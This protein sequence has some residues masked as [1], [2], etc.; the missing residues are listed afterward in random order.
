[1]YTYFIPFLA[2]SDSEPQFGEARHLRE[3]KMQLKGKRIWEKGTLL[4]KL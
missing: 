1:M 3:H 4:H 2:F